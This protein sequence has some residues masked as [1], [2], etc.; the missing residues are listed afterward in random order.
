MTRLFPILIA[1]TTAGC[2]D[3]VSENPT[4]TTSAIGTS[5][6]SSNGTTGATKQTTST[7]G[8]NNCRSQT[9]SCAVASCCAGLVCVTGICLS[10]EG[11]S[12]TSGSV[13]ATL[14]TTTGGS[15]GTTGNSGVVSTGGSSGTN[16]T[17]WTV[18]T[19]AGSGAPGF[20]NGAANSALFSAPFGVTVDQDN[21]VYVADTGNNIIREIAAGVVTT[22]AGFGVGGFRDGSTDTAQFMNP[23]GIAVDSSGNVYVADYGN[24]RIRLISG[25]MV[26]TLAGDGTAGFQDGA[27]AS[28]QFNEPTGVA[29]DSSG[30]VYVADLGNNR[31]REISNGTVS[32]LAGTGV[33]GFNN[34]PALSAQFAAP[35]RITVDGFGNVYVCDTDGDRIRLISN[36]TVSTI[37]GT[38]T[39]GLENGAVGSAEF[40]WP[41]GIAVDASGN[42][43]IGDYN[44]MKSGW[45]QAVP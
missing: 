42:L 9:E 21:N 33:H 10:A 30:N 34:G 6:A 17:S 22:F 3:G 39:P 29:V 31:I 37:A 5:L 28:A 4:T 41:E 23:T 27:A 16:G 40:N 36:G 44:T 32:T 26:S 8:G 12:G 11:T 19:F 25:G 13:N 18:S 24:N 45:S 15:S 38:G 2:L 7:T 35:N 43:Y 14:T 20:A 1:L